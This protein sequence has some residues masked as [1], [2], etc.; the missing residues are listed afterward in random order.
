M[1]ARHPLCETWSP[2]WACS[3]G[4][5][6]HTRSAPWESKGTRKRRDLSFHF[7]CVS[8]GSGDLGARAKCVPEDTVFWTSMKGKNI[9]PTWSLPSQPQ[10]NPTFPL[11]LNRKW[12]T[13]RIRPKMFSPEVL[14][15]GFQWPQQIVAARDAE[16][17]VGYGKTKCFNS[18]PY[19]QILFPSQPPGTS[20][21]FL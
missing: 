2:P 3:S 5:M 21:S 4:G 15:R 8:L 6:N 7:K 1:R 13:H 18:L 17:Q 14:P 12:V 19:T 20:S 16:G 9:P 10:S 11:H